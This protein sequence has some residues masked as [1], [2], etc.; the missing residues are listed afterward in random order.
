MKIL[1]LYIYIYIYIYIYKGL[2][3]TININKY[4]SIENHYTKVLNA[5]MLMLMW[6][7]GEDVI[8]HTIVPPELVLN[9]VLSF[10]KMK[11]QAK[12]NTT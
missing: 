5:K 7:D 9:Q 3:Y 8:K 2:V 12:L 1:Y 4:I 6:M 10:N 11:L